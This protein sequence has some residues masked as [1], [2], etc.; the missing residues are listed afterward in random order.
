MPTT[1]NVRQAAELLG[2][3]RWSLYKKLDLIPHFRYGKGKNSRLV[4]DA[5]ELIEYRDAHREVKPSGR[6]A[7]AA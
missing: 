1:L 2:I 5:D 4:F 6:P 3:S 7:G